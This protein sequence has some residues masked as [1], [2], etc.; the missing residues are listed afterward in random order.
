M[1]VT[2]ESAGPCNRKRWKIAYCDK[3]RLTPR[4]CLWGKGACPRNGREGQKKKTP[5]IFYGVGYR[6]LSPELWGK[7]CHQ[8]S[9]T[10]WLVQKKEEKL[11]RR[12]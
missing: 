9:V 6:R 11:Q 5:T 12:Y 7:L 3:I 1:K 2:K 10:L 4:H 8:K